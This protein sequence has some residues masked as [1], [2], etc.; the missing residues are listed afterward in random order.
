MIRLCNIVAL[1]L[2]SVT[3]PA[4]PG[5]SALAKVVAGAEHCREVHF[6]GGWRPTKSMKKAY[7]DHFLFG[8]P[9]EFR[10]AAVG[11]QEYLVA[12]VDQIGSHRD[13]SPD[14]FWINLRSGKVRSAT[15]TEW[16]SGQLVPQSSH[17]KGRSYEPKTEE[18]VLL[19]GKLFRKS[20]PQWPIPGEHARVSPDEKWLAVQSWEGQ[21]YRNG[22]IFAPRGKPGKFF[23]DLY[24]VSSDRRLV[25]VEG[26]HRGSLRADVP[27]TV[28]FWL[29]SR[30]FI[31]PLGSHLERMLVCE[32]PT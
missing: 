28:T 21:D 32:V 27:L 15:Q 30:Y 18:G 5:Q 26:E 19:E 10:K 13:Y 23:I 29:E 22:D 24:E 25:A 1:V 11:P 31:V 8:Y 7:V 12:A 20:G 9:Y 17:I 3:V 16:E 4:A 14:K 2:L 6:P